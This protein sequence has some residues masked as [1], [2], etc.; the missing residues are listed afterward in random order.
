MRHPRHHCQHKHNAGG[1]IQHGGAGQQLATYV[2]GNIA[3]VAYAGDDDRCCCRQQ[4]RRDLGDQAVT[5]GHQYVL[6]EG[7]FGA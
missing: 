6:L 3:A 4:Q 2:R 1:G 5:D 7:G